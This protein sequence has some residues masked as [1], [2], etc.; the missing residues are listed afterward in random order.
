MKYVAWFGAF[1]ATL[2]GLIYVVAFTS[3]G[4]SLVTPLIEAKIKE[5]TKLESKL[6]TF[7]LSMSD[8]EILLE[9]NKNN[10][11]LLKGN[12]SLF[13]QSFDIAYRVSLLE[14]KTLQPLTQVQLQSSF[15][16]EGSVVGDMAFMKVD[17]KSDVAKSNTSYHV[18]LT[19]LNPSSIIAK[20]ENLDLASLLY[21]G[22]QKEYASAI[23]NLDVDFKNITVHE[24]DG[25]VLLT[26]KEGKLNQA[27][28]KK[29]FNITIPPTA[30]D[31]QLNASLAGDSAEYTYFLSSNLAKLSSSGLVTP[32]PLALDVKYGV[33]IKELAVLKPMTNADVR[34]SFRLSGTAKGSKESL[35]VKGRS[36]IAAS[37][38]SFEALLEEFTPKS[39]RAS[40]KNMQLQKVLY[41]VKQPHYSD[42][43]FSMDATISDANPKNL[44]GKI[45]TSIKDGL[46][47]SKFLTK[48][49]EFA[50][51]MPT[52]RY[53][54]ST[55][56]KLNKN[57][58]DTQVN[59]ASTL[60]NLDVKQ[61]RFN[62]DDASIQSD[63][64]VKLHDLNRLY[65]VTQRN[66]KGALE[67]NGELKKAK[68]LDFTMFSNVAGGK[69][70]AK[71]HNDDFSANIKAMQTLDILDMLIYPKIFDSSIDGVLAYN[72]VAKKGDFKGE[73]VDGKF[74]KN[75]V[76]D[77]AKQY[78]YTDL[79]PER[80]KGNVN[81]NINKENILAS[82]DLNS[83]RSF[84][85][86]KDAKLNSKTKQMDAKLDISANGNPLEV[87]LKGD[88]NAPKVGVNAEKL[89]K[90]EAEKAITKEVNKLFKGLF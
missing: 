71:L 83:N 86:T 40:I 76:L 53:T 67:A 32:E 28:M 31:M 22:G 54:L 15:G 87:T 49:Y 20:V 79:Y 62:L 47:D 25:K 65:F 45:T 27:V 41:M 82:L 61:A 44:Q 7:S 59:L 29:D 21:L 78:A 80:F 26:T 72:L 77:L 19:N 51:L 84:I 81:A 74:T 63:Y 24:L 57:I 10:T 39:V 56:T 17:G 6:E 5:E 73:L 69:L 12:Y 1:V 2:L 37:D 18:E 46:L 60:A 89:I 14:L 42:G 66:L 50:S 85:K 43:Y 33:D 4:N 52:T 3:F 8:F 30:F 58:V 88:A 55:D 9:L 16:T 48:E 64:V 11:I 68:D 90:K 34:G 70:Q 75:Q 38:T 35:V 36:D 13:S 23:L